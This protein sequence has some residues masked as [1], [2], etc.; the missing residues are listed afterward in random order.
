M[1]W[2]GFRVAGAV[3]VDPVACRAYR[4]NHRRVKLWQTDIRRLSG[5]EVMRT[6]AIRPKQLALL[7]AC[8]PCQGFSTVRTRNG[9]R[10]NRDKRNDLIYEVLRLVRSLKPLTVMFENVPGLA[11][12]RRYLTFVGALRSL[13][14]RV[15]WAIL[16][17]A[18]FQVPQRRRRLVLLA[19][20]HGE[21]QFAASASN[22]AT[23]RQAIGDLL[24]PNRS[25][26]PLHNYSTRRSAK[27]ERRIRRIPADGGSRSAL[28]ARNQLPCHKRVNGF[29][30]VYGRMAWDSPA[31]T[32]TCGCINPSKGR[33]LHPEAHRAITLREAAL[34]QTF[35]NTYRFPLN[36][37]RYP[38]AG[39]IGN[40][41]PPE[42]IRRHAI[43]LHRAI[44]AN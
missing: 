37:G 2:A 29:R 27:I 31:P 33:F 20:R 23:V 1:R 16:N 25:R 11:S 8:P 41:L 7:A 14:Y 15:K 42:F 19:S 3:D 32:I 5:G 35:P 26:D 12:D 18:D 30:D 6:L 43:A 36:H 4:L 10:R 21:P 38:I 24:P 44:L 17:A 9:N 40:A 13:G 28:G 34:L 22:R 39:L